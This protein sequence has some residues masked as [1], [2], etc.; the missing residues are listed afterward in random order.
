MLGGIRENAAVYQI[1]ST[2]AVV[3]TVDFITPV[4]ND[5]YSFGAVAA[6]NAISDIYAMGA[7]PVFALNIVEFPVKSLPLYILEAILKGG[8]DKATEAGVCIAGGHSVD[9]NAP[10]YGMAVTGIVDPANIISKNG[11]KPGDILILTKPL[12][13][14]IIT[15]AL[16]RELTNAAL[17]KEVY[18]IMAQLNKKASAV[19]TSI[20]V[21]ACTDVTGFGLLGHL[22]EM[23]TGGNVAARLFLSHIP[24]IPGARKLAVAGAVPSGAYNNYNYIKK[25]VNWNGINNQADKMILCDPQTS[26]GL[27]MAVPG[28]KADQLQESLLKEGCLT[29]AKIGIISAKEGDVIEVFPDQYRF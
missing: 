27:L 15:T 6:A 19:M 17:E 5:P 18:K 14:G 1:N 25:K 22:S 26:G 29:A 4:L 10:K 2:L 24:V 21:N 12:G 8:R 28:E 7:K 20:G 9:D 16:D 13:T 3:Q 23:L 11:A